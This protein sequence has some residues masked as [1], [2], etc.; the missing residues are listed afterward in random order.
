VVLNLTF[1][2]TTST[3]EDLPTQQRETTQ[4]GE[5]PLSP[6]YVTC[7]FRHF[8]ESEDGSLKTSTEI[9]HSGVTSPRR[10]PK[11]VIAIRAF[12]SSSS[13]A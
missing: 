1:I 9:I 2:F 3:E 10:C 11:Q 8:T 4:L 12:G 7:Q 13:I 5:A 6:L